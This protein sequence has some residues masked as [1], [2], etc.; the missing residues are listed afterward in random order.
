M[1]YSHINSILTND[2]NTNGYKQL[3]AIFCEIDSPEVSQDSIKKYLYFWNKNHYKHLDFHYLQ[4]ALSEKQE[5]VTGLWLSVVKLEGDLTSCDSALVLNVVYDYMKYS[6]KIANPETNSE[7]IE[8]KE[9]LSKRDSVKLLEI[10][11][12]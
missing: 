11:S 7:F 6:M 3:K 4:P 2:S 9:E 5:P 12:T 10:I 8:M 1:V